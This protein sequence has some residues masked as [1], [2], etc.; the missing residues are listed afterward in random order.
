MNKKLI[1]IPVVLVAIGAGI[2]LKR[3]DRLTLGSELTLHGNVDIRQVELAFNASGRIDQMMVQEG[4]Q[5]A[6]GQVLAKLDTQRLEL[7]LAQAEAQADVLRSNAEKLKSGSRPE[8]VRQAEAQRDAARAAADDARQVY[9]RQQ[10]LVAKHF[11]SQQ[12]ADSAKNNLDGALNRLKAAEEAYRLAVLGPRKEDKAAAEAG[13][14]AQNAA[15]AGLRHDVAEGVLKAPEA[16]IVENR[17]LEPGDMA[18]PQKA[19]F[20]IALTDPVWAR[21]YLPE[22]ALGRVPVGAR[23]TITTDSHPDHK[24]VGWVGYISPAAEF[25]PKMVETTELRTSLVYQARVFACDG[26]GELRQGMPVTVNI[27][28]DQAA[29]QGTPCGNAKQ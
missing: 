25:T 10:D 11:V 19:V 18:S 15:V 16:G 27:A 24:Y 9:K 13:L 5:V 4:D 21:V 29:G 1:V 12:Q 23:A 17:I 6:K 20:T 3:H 2:W 22:D 26:K 14:A 28:F 7:A 8:E